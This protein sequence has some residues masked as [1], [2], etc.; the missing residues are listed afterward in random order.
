MSHAPRPITGVDTHAH[1]FA[2][3]LPMTSGRRYSPDYDATLAAY[4]QHL[5]THNFSHGVLIQP[6]FL[7]TDN[8]YMLDAVRQYS[9]RLKA[10]V[11][12]EPNISEPA[13][14]QLT[15]AGAV[16]ARLNLIGKTPADYS[17][18]EWQSFF[19]KLKQVGWSLEIHRHA[20]DIADFVP[21]ILESGVQV[22]IDHF[23]RPQGELSPFFEGHRAFLELLDNEQLWVKVSA[24]YRNNTDLDA[25]QRMMKL[26]REAMGGVS[27]ML[28]GSDWPHTQ[29]EEVTS[30]EAQYGIMEALL[31]DAEERKQV[32]QDNPRSLFHLA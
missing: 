17:Q 26:L 11:V 1:V 21:A 23:G 13:L 29:F 22:V 12:V 27:R 18:S 9:D 16:G 6:S 3:D 28:W 2:M 14:E 20:D 15:R 25:M 5:D 10:V 31:A 4:I 24:G 8:S 7:G 30:Y 19:K 32:L